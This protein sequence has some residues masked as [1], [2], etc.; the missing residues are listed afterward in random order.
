MKKKITDLVHDNQLFIK[1][2]IVTVLGIILTTLIISL[3]VIEMSENV[4]LEAYNDSNEKI[5]MQIRDDYY[6]LHS[7]IVNTLMDCQNSSS[8]KEYL[9]AQDVSSSEESRI[10][11]NMTSQFSN[12]GI[13]HNNTA[14]NL[15]LVGINGKTYF[16][17][18][19]AGV[20]NYNDIINSEIV[21]KA[22]VNPNQINYQYAQDGFCQTL[23]NDNVIV[24]IKVLKDVGNKA[25]YGLA[26]VMIE[27]SD[28]A[29]FYNSLIDRKVNHVSIVS[30][31][32][33]VISSNNDQL[34]QNSDLIN[35]VLKNSSGDEGKK[36][37]EI[38]GRGY[39]VN[40]IRMPFMDGLFISMIDETGLINQ[41]NFIP[42]VVGTAT[43][44][45]FIFM[46]IVIIL[47]RKAMRPLNQIV[48]E[49]PSITQGDFSNHIEVTSADELYSPKNG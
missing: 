4:Y 30:N 18:N 9:T 24:A 17:N 1:I 28:F 38:D 36:R 23:K 11:Y 2:S 40:T 41:I 49:I 10:I 43:V 42:G 16:P 46:T 22:L 29:Y 27:Q 39:T 33:L 37:Q 12:Y 31:D 7:D 44:I 6:D 32:G 8:L 47:I 19:N 13:L 25:P 20:D 21:Q 5:M 45:S 48:E 26:I 3:F 34:G 14:S 15:L 35:Q